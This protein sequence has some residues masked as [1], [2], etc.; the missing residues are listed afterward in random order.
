MLADPHPVVR[1]APSVRPLLSVVVPTVARPGLVPLL[2]SLRAPWLEWVIVFDTSCRERMLAVSQAQQELASRRLDYWTC[3]DPGVQ[4]RMFEGQPLSNWG[5]P[6]RNFGM[7]KATGEWLMFSQDD[8]V[9]MPAA[10]ALLEVIMRTGSQGPKLVRLRK[11]PRAAELVWRELGVFRE[12]MVDG[13]CLLVPNDQS[14][15]G[16][17]GPGYAGDWPFVRDTV[18]A[19]E[20]PIEWRREVIQEGR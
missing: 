11:W 3:D 16:R 6:A 8:Q 7:R 9:F 14:R 1:D 15:L 4:E 5:Q 2:D 12:G 20:G 13:D 17:W 10:A 18:A 19:W